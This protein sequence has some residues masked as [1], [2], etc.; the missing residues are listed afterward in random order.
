MPSL[1][2]QELDKMLPH[3]REMSLLTTVLSWDR[4][5]IQC[6]TDT[7]RARNNP[8]RSCDRLASICGLEY[9]AQ[10]IAVH[11]NLL[12]SPCDYQATAGYIG[13]I[14]DLKVGLSRLD[15]IADDLEIDATLLIDMGSSLMYAFSVRTPGATL[16]RGRASIFLHPPNKK[17]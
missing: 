11:V 7:H 9:A 14:K 1:S 8:L 16:L 15:T 17:A 4:S 3:G 12:R 2:K 6:M 5:S 13:G 10:A